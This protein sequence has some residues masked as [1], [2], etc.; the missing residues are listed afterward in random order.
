MQNKRR[1]FAH[2]IRPQSVVENLSLSHLPTLLDDDSSSRRS[3]NASNNKEM[4]NGDSLTELPSA[5][6]QLQHLVKGRSVVLVHL[7]SVV[8]V[9]F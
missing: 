4:A 3:S 6:F 9:V 7:R 1:P 2:K 8:N 5:S